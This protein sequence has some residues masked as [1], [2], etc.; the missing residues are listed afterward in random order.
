MRAADFEPKRILCPLDFSEH[1][2]LALKYAAAGAREYGA[3]V[4]V[5][6]ARNFDLPRYFNRSETPRLIE[7][8]SSAKAAAGADLCSYVKQTLGIAVETL[9]IRYEVLDS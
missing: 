3:E 7:E 8:L 2:S 1:S 6:H 4:T 9:S 5:L